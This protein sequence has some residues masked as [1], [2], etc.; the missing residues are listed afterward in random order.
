MHWLYGKLGGYRSPRRPNVGGSCLPQVME[1]LL[2]YTQDL[3]R[4]FWFAFD[5]ATQ[6]TPSFMQIVGRSGAARIQQTYSSTRNAGSF[7]AA[8]INSVQAAKADWVTIS[9][10]QINMFTKFG[11]YAL[12][13]DA[14]NA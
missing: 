14:T 10:L 6:G 12:D 4:D 3:G 1:V 11:K 8:F 5:N 9:D 2:P 7:P 13:I